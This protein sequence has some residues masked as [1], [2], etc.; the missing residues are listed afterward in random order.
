MIEDRGNGIHLPLR[1]VGYVASSAGL[2]M[3]E[4]FWIQ[5]DPLVPLAIVL[6]PRGKNSLE[7]DLK[8]FAANRVET[9]VSLLEPEEAAWL[10]LADEGALAVRTGMNF[11]S[12]PIQDVHVP[13]NLTAFRVF[14]SEL[15]ERLRKGE[16]IGM[17][18]R[19]SI[20]RAPLTAAC[21]LIQLGWKAKDA[22]M[23]IEAARGCPIPDTQEQLRW[24]L[25]YRAQP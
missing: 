22:L 17:H 10:G 19:G 12:F 20:G 1:M 5:G 8:A 14:V 11:L 3:K 2:R 15:A 4:V 25:N 24:I 23:A 18:C 7:E 9:L 6:C 21:T 13:A 16:R